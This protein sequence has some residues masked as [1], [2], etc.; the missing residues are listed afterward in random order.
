MAFP[1]DSEDAGTLVIPLLTNENPN[2]PCRLCRKSIAE[3]VFT[4]ERDGHASTSGLCR[5]CADPYV[6]SPHYSG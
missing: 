6:L 1:E 4:L 2:I 5:D 3:Y